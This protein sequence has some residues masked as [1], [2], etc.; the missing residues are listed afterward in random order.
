MSNYN[1][2]YIKIHST[3]KMYSN[4]LR[5]VVT[6]LLLLYIHNGAIYL[7]FPNHFIGQKRAFH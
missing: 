1:C 4:A 5:F 6:M 3:L 7:T 2:V